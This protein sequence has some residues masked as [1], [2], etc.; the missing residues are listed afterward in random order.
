MMGVSDRGRISMIRSAVLIQYTRVTDRQTD[1]RTDGRTDGRTGGIGV[2]YT[3][4]SIY[5]VA[6][7]NHRRRRR[8]QEEG[9]LL[10]KFGENIFSGKCRV[11]LDIFLIFIHNYVFRQKCHPLKAPTPM[12]QN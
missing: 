4:Y 9:Q 12:G 7:K 8:E 5:A 1:R 3:R 11:N 2:A 6:R 10:P